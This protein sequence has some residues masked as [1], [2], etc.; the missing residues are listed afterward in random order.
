VAIGQGPILVTPIQQAI[1]EA[2]L[3]TDGRLVTPTLRLVAPTADGSSPEVEKHG[4][5]LPASTLEVIQQA[6]WGVVNDS[7]TGTKAI[8]KGFDVCGKTGTAQVI[9]ASVGVKNEMELPPQFRDHAWFVGF[10]PLAHPEIAF[11]VFVEHGG[12]GGDVAAPIARDVL[13]TYFKNRK[14][15]VPPLQPSTEVAAGPSGAATRTF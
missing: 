12:H 2:A 11:A 15:P 5:P 3:A 6:M 8:L 1:V 4:E 10:A 13:E 14:K 9:A 7:G